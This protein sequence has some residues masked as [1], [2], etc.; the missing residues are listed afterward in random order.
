MASVRSV[1][2]KIVD[3]GSAQTVSKLGTMVDRVGHIE[4]S[5]E[6]FVSTL[7][8]SRRVLFSGDDQMCSFQPLKC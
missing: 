7:T 6:G 4:Y 2:V 3:L 1:Q 8:C 5:G